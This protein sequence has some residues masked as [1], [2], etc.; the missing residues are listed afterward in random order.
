MAKEHGGTIRR[1]AAIRS[2]I[3]SSGPFGRPFS[4]SCEH[5]VRYRTQCFELHVGVSV[6]L[7]VNLYS[8]RTLEA[9]SVPWLRMTHHMLDKKIIG[10]S[11]T[12]LL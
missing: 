12:D 2:E 4:V 11:Y 9:V 7:D 1:M 3:T 8:M 6:M 10:F 5:P